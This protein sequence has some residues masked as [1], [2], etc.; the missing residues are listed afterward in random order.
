MLADGARKLRLG[1]RPASTRRISA[2]VLAGGVCLAFAAAALAG[3]KIFI[4]HGPAGSAGVATIDIT[5]IARNQHPG[6]LTRFE[7]NNIPASCAGYSPT[8]VS[9]TFPHPIL[10]SRG[11]FHAS[12]KAN[13]GRVSFM[14]NGHFTGLKAAGV[15]RVNGAVP[16]CAS[17]DTGRV[18]WSAK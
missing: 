9:D 14:V 17:A 6:K 8:A 3:A 10:V 11:K 7:F 18:H 1:L 16:G 5:L 2:L 15:L 4:L 12:V 13:G